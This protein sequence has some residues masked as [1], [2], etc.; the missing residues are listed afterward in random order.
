MK[1]E[2]TLSCLIIFHQCATCFIIFVTF[3]ALPLC[4]IILITCPVHHNYSIIFIISSEAAGFAAAFISFNPFISSTCFTIIRRFHHLLFPFITVH[5]SR[6]F[7]HFRR[8]SSLSM[9][10]CRAASSFITCHV[11]HLHSYSIMRI[12]PIISVEFLTFLI[13]HH[14]FPSW[15]AGVSS[16]FSAVSQLIGLPQRLRSLLSSSVST[17]LSKCFIISVVF[18]YLHD[19]H[20][21]PQLFIMFNMNLYHVL[22]CL[23]VNPHQQPPQSLPVGRRRRPR[24]PV[25]FNRNRTMSSAES[26][27]T[28]AIFF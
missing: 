24:R 27:S 22:P 25:L 14:H 28:T 5:Y 13:A 3:Y 18:H 7:H 6:H 1:E 11:H 12:N 2:G 10:F 19:L 17:I 20:D 16:M 26:S 9:I 21:Y 15:R 23:V 4:F 8:V